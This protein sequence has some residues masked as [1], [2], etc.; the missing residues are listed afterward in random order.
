MAYYGKYTTTVVGSYSVPRWYEVLEREVESGIL[1][2]GDMADAQ[3]RVSQ[4][5]IVDQEIAGI[6]IITGGEMHR[7]TNNRHAP[8]NA[9]LNFFWEKIPGFSGE[10]RPKPITA[11]DPNVFHPAA[12]CTAKIEYADLGLVD[13]FYG[14]SRFARKEIKITMTGPHMLAKVA[15]DEYY[16]DMARFM[17]D[18]AKVLNHNF[19]ELEKAGC[20]HIQIDE[21]LF[22]ISDDQE[23]EAAVDAINLALEGVNYATVQVHICQGNYAVGEDYDGQIGHRYFDTG[24]YPAEQICNINCDALLIEHDLTPTYEGLLGNKQLFIGAADVQDL[25]IETPETIVQRIKRHSWLPPEQTLI[26]TS[27]G[28]NHLPRPIAFGKLKAI[29]DAKRILRGD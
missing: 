13:E 11:K 1:S 14:I 27:C 29:A 19:I 7:R 22:A 6:D 2:R 21:P 10:T 8:P 25:A 17:E 15:H 23:V 20:R 3:F 28:L 26:T 16:G 24:R 12:V 18:L 5:A 9:M 4:A